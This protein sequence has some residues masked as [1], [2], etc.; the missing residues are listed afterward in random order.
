VTVRQ[1]P[2]LV[3]GEKNADLNLRLTSQMM[4]ECW[5]SGLVAAQTQTAGRAFESLVQAAIFK[6]G[7]V[8]QRPS[9]TSAQRI[10]VL[11][12]RNSITLGSV[13]SGRSWPSTAVAAIMSQ[14]SL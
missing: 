12:L 11:L 14:R 8:D 5:W 7:A 10:T 4:R 9:V 13:V 6:V 2:I 1:Q 3:S